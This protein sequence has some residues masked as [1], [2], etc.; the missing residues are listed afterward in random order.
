MQRAAARQSRGLTLIEMCL[1][2]ALL[3]VIAAV[4]TPLLEGSFSRANL[5]SAA[6]LLTAAWSR[7]R[8]AAM[9]SG[10][11]HVFRFEPKGTRFQI[12]TLNDLGML[13]SE[14]PDIDDANSEYGI[15]E[16]MRSPQNRL[17]E[18]VAFAAAEIAASSQVAATYGET[19]GT[20]WSSPILFHADGT[21]S[22]ATVLLANGDGQT[23]RLTQRGLTGITQ[24]SDLG[25]EAVPP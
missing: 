4:A 2:L 17:P 1:V 3:V 21:T 25:H 14:T 18:G 7:A 23:V 22:D 11:T 20:N 15:D 24:V 5:Q 10:V 9:E 8:L 6:D 13:E 19:T 16:M 12:I